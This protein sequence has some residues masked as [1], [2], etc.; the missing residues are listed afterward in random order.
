MTMLYS[1]GSKEILIMAADSAERRDYS[2]GEIE[3]VTCTK[4]FAYENIGCLST[5]GA[6]DHNRIYEFLGPKI[7]STVTDVDSLADEVFHYLTKEYKPH[8]LGFGDVG[9]HVGGFSSNGECRLF[10]VF[11][12]FDRPRPYDQKRPGYKKKGHSPSRENVV[13][14]YNGRNELAEMVVRYFLR[15]IENKGSSCLEMTNRVHLVKL[16]DLVTR[17]SAE[18]SKD[19]GLPFSYHLVSP[20]NIITTL[21]NASLCPLDGDVIQKGLEAIKIL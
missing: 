11:W 12:G 14:L 21:K 19:V 1:F 16:A 5:W 9:Y 10:H 2:S 17:F 6:R 8:A 13:F 18:I 7:N 20:E 4:S 15:E 3:Y